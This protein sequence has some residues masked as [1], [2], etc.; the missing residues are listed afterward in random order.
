MTITDAAKAIGKSEQSVRRA[1]KAGKLKAVK[2]KGRYEI[3]ESDLSNYRS[4]SQPID[5]DSQAIISLKA[6]IET[7]ENELRDTRQEKDRQIEAAQQAAQETSQRH[8]TIVLQLTKQL[9]N[10]QQL[11]EYH[12]EPWWRRWFS[13]GKHK[14]E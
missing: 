7:L 10:Q 14:S 6:R 12:Q 4:D 8:D 5:T 13:K 1:I 2:V 11:L 9:D 3:E